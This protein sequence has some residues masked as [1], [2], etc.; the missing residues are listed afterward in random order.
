MHTLLDETR[1]DDMQIIGCQTLFDF[2]N[3]Q[4]WSFQ[5]FLF[6]SFWF[7]MS[8]FRI[9]NLKFCDLQRDGTYMFNLEKFIPKLCQ[10]AQ[11]VGQDERVEPLR[12]AA[13]QS[14]SAMVFPFFLTSCLSTQNITWPYKDMNFFF[15]F[16]F[17]SFIDIL[18][19]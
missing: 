5:L 12:S 9:C 16:Y 3:S 8:F 19:L 6:F 4:V 1:Q 15:I 2:V 14:L 13:L 17:G 10:L 18:F 7:S 11:E